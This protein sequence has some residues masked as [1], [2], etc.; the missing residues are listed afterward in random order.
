MNAAT[1]TGNKNSSNCG[2]SCSCNGGHTLDVSRLLCESGADVNAATNNGNTTLTVASYRGR[3]LG[4]S[5]PSSTSPSNEPISLQ[6]IKSDAQPSPSP[7]RK[8]HIALAAYLEA[9]GNW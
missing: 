6:E 1:N 9:E 8:T 2:C 3:H 7:S 5:R 4:T